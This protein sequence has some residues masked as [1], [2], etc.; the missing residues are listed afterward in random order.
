MGAATRLKKKMELADEKNQLKLSGTSS[1]VKI[2]TTE[3]YE[4]S[5]YDVFK[6]MKGNRPIDWKHVDEIKKAMATKDLKDPIKVNQDFEVIDGQHTLEARKALGLPVYFVAS[7]DGDLTSVQA[8]NANRKAWSIDNYMH[9][10][11]ERGVADYTTFQ[12]YVEKYRLPKAIS[13][14]LLYGRDPNS[15]IVFG[16]ATKDLNKLFMDGKFRV[17]E[18][19]H[20]KQI[21]DKLLKLEPLFSHWNNSRFMQAL[22]YVMRNPNFK[23]TQFLDKCKRYPWLLKQMATGQ[24]Y[25]E[26]IEQIYNYKNQNKVHLRYLG[27]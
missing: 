2:S 8:L 1:S 21:G 9:S 26:L 18:L 13:M 14:E 10:Y 23:F 17:N 12:W 16:S 25:T 24:L 15:K 5:E 27:E 7:Q 22:L 3:I 19:E 20:A 6:R 4:T 11:I